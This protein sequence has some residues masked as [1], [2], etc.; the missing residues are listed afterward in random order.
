MPRAAG[1]FR[2][3]SP[4]E[5]ELLNRLWAAQTQLMNLFAPQQKL[6][7]KTRV[8]AKVTKRYDTATTAAQR[9]LRDHPDV[10]SD[11]DRE[12][13]VSA[14]DTV[15]PAQ[16]RRT[17]GDLQNRLLHLAKQRG[18]VPNRPRRYHVYDS[19]RKLAPLPPKKRASSDES[20]TTPKRAS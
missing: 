9:L 8:G 13:I 19:R 3:D 14:L 10:L 16:L 15:N 1:Y 5:L 7:S 11:A 6:V 2:Y 17:I 18:P 4:R 20:T 12:A